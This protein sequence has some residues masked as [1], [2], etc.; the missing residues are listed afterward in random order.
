VAVTLRD[1]A[2]HAGVSPRTVSNVVHDYPHVSAEMRAR[3]QNSLDALSYRPNLVAR[4]LRRG[5]TGIITLLVPDIVVPYFGE[6]AHE[7]VEQASQLGCTVMIDET[8]GLP[9][10][11]R[12][13]LDTAA[14]SSWVDGVLLSSIGLS[15]RAL[16]GLRSSMAVVLLGE[17]TA[18]SALDHVGIDNVAAAY[19]A[20]TH[21]LDLGRTRVAAVGG[22]GNPLDPTSRLR[23]RGYQRALAGHGV[24]ERTLHVRT[25]DYRRHS[26]A[27][28]VREL[29]DGPEPPDALF[30]FSDE[31][32]AGALRALHDRGVRVPEDV[33]VVG[34]DDADG[35]RFLTPSLTSV[36][37]DRP[38]IARVSLEILLQRIDG[39]DARPRDVRVPYELVVRESSAPAAGR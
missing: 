10:R 34:F 7:V 5:R 17:R 20:V 1:V 24:P 13:L 29:F 12:A 18:Q 35:S 19:D 23:L 6:L 30:C 8:G 36:R 28:A 14:E 15:A 4:G 39:L 38:E 27:E 33:A 9:E 26:A 25:A 37:P 3:V 31:L 21:L 16:A 11:E 22:R 32:A 2:A